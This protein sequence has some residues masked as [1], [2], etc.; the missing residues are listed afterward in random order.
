WAISPIIDLTDYD[1]PRL[2][3]HQAAN[4]FDNS[5][6]FLEMTRT[7]VREVGGE[8]VEVDLP[9]AP[10]GNSW[11]FS[12]SGYGVLDNMAGKKIEIGF[13]YT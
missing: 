3:V 12:D 2:F 7:V 13:N 11:T 10:I 4:Y 1:E 9:Y 6:N 5:V 8:W